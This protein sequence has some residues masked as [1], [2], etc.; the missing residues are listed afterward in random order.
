[1]QE[2]LRKIKSFNQLI[3]TQEVDR[4]SEQGREF[5]RRSVGA[6]E[7]MQLLIRDLIDYARLNATDRVFEPTPL[8]EL[9]ADVLIDLQESI[10]SSRAV[11][12]VGD[13]PTALVIQLLF[14]QL[15]QNLLTNALKFH[16]PAT[17]PD[18]VPW[19]GHRP[20]HLSARDAASWWQHCSPQP[21]RRGGHVCDA[22][23]DAAAGP[24]GATYLLFPVQCAGQH[25]QANFGEAAFGVERKLA[26]LHPVVKR[27]FG[28]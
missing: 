22:V 20:R 19:N 6:A 12:Q 17:H 24:V 1:L 4:L 25:L 28:F 16:Q 21:T 11:V 14:R 23:A 18:R 15:L 27:R 9:V 26:F 10:I 3:L 5:F 13:L 8:T 7:R 2:P